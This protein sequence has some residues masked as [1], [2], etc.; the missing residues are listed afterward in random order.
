MAEF[1][2]ANTHVLAGVHDELSLDG[3]H[4]VLLV[5]WEELVACNHEGVHVGDGSAGCQDAVPALPTDDLA[6]FLHTN[7]HSSQIFF[8]Y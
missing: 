3:P 8:T 4:A 5:L 1:W 7:L 2:P 6:H